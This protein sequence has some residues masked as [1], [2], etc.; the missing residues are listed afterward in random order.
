M[1][2]LLSVILVTSS[3]NLGPTL[4]FSY[5]P[6]PRPTPR[7]SKPIYSKPAEVVDAQRRSAS[8]S[9]S[10]DDDEPAGTERWDV[11]FVRGEATGDS[12]EDDRETSTTPPDSAAT[13]DTPGYANYLGGFENSILAS[14]LTPR[15]EM[16]DKKF[17][18]VIEELAF[19]GHPVWLGRKGEEIVESEDLGR[20]RMRSRAA[21]AHDVMESSVQTLSSSVFEQP[22][23]TSRELPLPDIQ[24]VTISDQ[25]NV[26][27]KPPAS[28]TP[29]GRVHSVYHTPDMSRHTSSSSIS[30]P[31][32]GFTFPPAQAPSTESA[33]P[34]PP[35]RTRPRKRD[36]TAEAL[37]SFNLVLVIDTPPDQHLSSHLDVYYR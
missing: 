4:V 15:R 35:S 16:C 28:T 9:S 10:S 36:Y 27:S 32:A 3:A 22:S 6:T 8:T 31:L 26:P 20:A 37:E 11:R 19:I 12:S 7:L 29:A 33:V 1:A 13:K 23:P 30:A 17:E 14:L 21:A 5:P 24:Q 18:M 34:S 2:T 25:L